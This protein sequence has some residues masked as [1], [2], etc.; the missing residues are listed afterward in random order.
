MRANK[1]RILQALPIE[2]PGVTYQTGWLET[3]HC[4]VQQWENKEAP[5]NLAVCYI[6]LPLRAVKAALP[7]REC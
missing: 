1:Q 5:L 6:L 4:R 3:V 7:Q 2:T